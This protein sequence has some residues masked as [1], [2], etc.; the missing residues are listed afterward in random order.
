MFHRFY[1]PFRVYWFWNY[2]EFATDEYIAIQLEHHFEGLILNRL[3]G[4]NKLKWRLFLLS[5]TY[6]GRRLQNK[7][8][9]YLSPLTIY[10]LDKPYFEL[11]FGIENIIKLGRV[12]FT[13]RMT[14]LNHW[15]MRNR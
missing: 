13:W 3:P 11:G 2:A 14:H 9:Q 7:S 1:F 6:I 5:K 4:I 15:L 12:D 8:T 10:N